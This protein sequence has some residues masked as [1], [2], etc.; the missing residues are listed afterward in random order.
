MSDPFYDQVQ[1]ALD[2]LSQDPGAIIYRG[3][4]G[5][6]AL[7]PGPTGYVLAIGTDGLPGWYD[8]NNLP[9]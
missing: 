7:P 8:P 9:S 3:A 5:W 6:L 4:D 2:V 1:N